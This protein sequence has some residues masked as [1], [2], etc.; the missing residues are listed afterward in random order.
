MSF[1]TIL[2]NVN[3]KVLKHL[4][5][6]TYL[7]NSNLRNL[8]IKL[9]YLILMLGHL[10]KVLSFVEVIILSTF[11][12]CYKCVSFKKFIFNQIFCFKSICNVFYT[13]VLSVE[14][15]FV[16]RIENYIRVHRNSHQVECNNE[17]TSH[18]QF[19]AGF[20]LIRSELL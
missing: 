1:I 14:E 12:L 13:L 6:L 3:V 2:K 19:M 20:S 8:I 10:C 18:L 16:T 15:A 11:Y 7:S 5:F 9:K 17:K 4:G